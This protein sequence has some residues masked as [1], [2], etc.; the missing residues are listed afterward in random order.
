MSTKIQVLAGVV[1]LVALLAYTLVHT[2][3]LLA[4]Y[5]QP[6]WV[7]FVA[8]FGIELAVVSLSLRIGDLRRTGQDFRFFMFVLVSV[9]IVSAL[10]NIAEG[11][12]VAHGTDLTFTTVQQLDVIQ[13]IIGLTATGLISLIVLALSEIIGTDV[14]TMVKETEKQRR[15]IEREQSEIEVEK[16]YPYPIEQARATKSEQKEERI[17]ALVGLI[18]DNPDI[19]PA[20]AKREI[21]I[22][23][24]TFYAYRD[25]LTER[26]IINKNGNGLTVVSDN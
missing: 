9:V 5:V 23:K 8:A 20:Q 17:A 4:D 22:S 10:A 14:Q 6:G 11:F 25:E 15:K 2:G 19:G 3:G 12:A 26:G 16:S 13:A 18:A 21:G 24:T 1:S 7:G